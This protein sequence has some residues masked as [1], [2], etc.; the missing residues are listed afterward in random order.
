MEN[1]RGKLSLPLL[2]GDSGS[3]THDLQI[4]N[5]SLYQLSYIPISSGLNIVK[6]RL[7]GKFLLLISTF[8]PRCGLLA[9]R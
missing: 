1:K 5:L 2:R 8:L 6:E 3:R 9:R 4:A 7:F